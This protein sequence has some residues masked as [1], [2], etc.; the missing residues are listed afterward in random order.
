M[1]L[2]KIRYTFSV[3]LC[4][5]AIAVSKAQVSFTAQVV[6]ATCSSNGSILVNATGGSS[7]NYELASTCLALPLFQQNSTFNNLAP[8]QYTITVTDG[9]TGASASQTVTVGGTYQS[10]N[11]NL[12]CGNCSIEATTMGGSAP[13]EYSISS[14][15][16]GGPFTPNTP[17]GNAI[18]DNIQSA[19]N[20]WVKVTDAC[21]NVSVET[22]QTG[23]GSVTNFTHE[24]GADGQIH[25][26]SVTG[27]TGVIIYELSS[28]AGTF[29]NTTGVFPQ[30]QWGC[31]MMLTVA[32]GCTSITKTI[33]LKPY[34]QS[35]CSNFAEGTA[36]LGNVFNGVPPY[37]FKYTSPTNI[38]TSTMTNELTGLPINTNYYLFQVVD[39]CGNVSDA[40]Y[41]QKKYPLFEQ[42][43]P[44]DCDGN[45]I[46]LYTPN[47]GCSG[48]FDA[49]SWPFDVTCLS[50]S[51]V[52]TKSVDTAGVSITFNGNTP[53]AW[54]LA[55]EDGC[56]DKMVCRDSVILLLKPYCDSIQ[57]SLVD[58][59]TCD[60]GAI[61][62]RPM[63][64]ENGVFVLLDA[65]DDVLGSNSTG[66]FHVPDSGSYK[67]TLSLPNCGVFEATAN[68][69]YWQAV[70]PVMQTLIYNTVIGGQC[71][72]V[73]QL[74]IDPLNGPFLLTGGPNNITMQLDAS[75]LTSSCQFY[76]VHGLLPGEYQLTETDHCGSKN[77]HLPAPVYNLQAVPF[78][79]CPG[80]GTITVFGAQKLPEWQ[81]WGTVNN[82]T[83]NWPSSIT[84]NYAL[85]TTS[86][87]TLTGQSGSPY[88]FVNVEAGEHKIY[89]YTLNSQCPVDTVTVIVPEADTLSFDVS[90]GILC[91]N[92]STT[93]LSFEVLSGKPPYTIERVNCNNPALVLAT[94]NV[95]GNTLSLPGFTTGDY[96]FRLVDSCITSLDHQFSVQYFQDDIGLT[97]NCDNSFT[98]SVDSL[99][100]TYTWLDA[101][102]NTVGNSQKLTLPNPNTAVE[103]TVNVDIGQCVIQRS[104][105]VPATEIIPSVQ[106]TGEPY[107]CIN[108]SMTLAAVTNA[109]E[110]LWNNGSTTSSIVTPDE[111]EYTV[112]VT[113]EFGCTSTTKFVLT[114]D[115]PE[116]DIQIMSGG[117]GFGLNCFQDS[118]GIL[119]V[120]PMVGI[121]P[122]TYQWSNQAT[123]QTITNLKTG[124]F[125]VTLTDAI[126]C[127]DSAKLLLTEPELFVPTL[128]YISPRCF[129]I[130][131]G[132]IEIP[133]WTGGAGGVKASLQGS[134]P[135]L[136]PIIFDQLPPGSYS[137]EISD[138]NGCTVDSIFFFDSPQQRYLELGEDL[139]LE[140]GDSTFLR[141]QVSFAPVDSFLWKSN[142]PRPL[143]ELELW[144]Q[145]IETSF[146]ALTVWDDKG[147]PVEDKMNILVNKEL[148]IFAPTAFSPNGDGFNDRFTI[149]AR[150]SAVRMIQRLQ[151]F[152]RFGEKVF[153]QTKFDPNDE[154]MGW[155]GT[156]DGQPLNPGVFTWK[157]E[158]EFIDG[159]VELLYGDVVLVR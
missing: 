88:T 109:N 80:S 9:G 6:D 104:I 62:D 92:A 1:I 93:S 45:T 55:V 98:I 17:V 20:Y 140:L 31:N 90:S 59:F 110:Y 94:Y 16:L 129:G 149:F 53:G 40:I 108:D 22:C 79:N 81:N 58:R 82:A 47:G 111:G 131:D 159:R 158:I 48:G 84:D 96:C 29:S 126:G 102:G 65:N 137:I 99:N 33:K 57:A 133:F 95:N 46:T 146:Y 152:D 35:I 101:N 11:V 49:D 76:S 150:K 5:A 117:S 107:F 138:A 12:F 75:D 103:Y 70:D 7:L 113:N 86:N 21:G 153:E 122:F 120:N 4:I 34:V 52:V 77:I 60:N 144:V 87:G 42:A 89:L 24:I 30:S 15:G 115:I 28:T 134:L 74:V 145:P 119:T 155:N 78:G 142:D 23:E 128:N 156:L 106:I 68:I 18:F 63:S 56:E 105:T 100:A 32:D 72:T 13:F 154:P 147:C 27:G 66:Q 139:A 136:A 141:P 112:T 121:A 64:I 38:V 91:D 73:Y 36:T 69:G 151:L 124:E 157:A 8:C 43:P 97:F 61:S 10:P 54:E 130:D 14:V 148:D 50:C 37:T 51:P 83:I 132:V 71:K 85:D 67:V 127:V 44:A 135:K 114:R 2:M 143:M 118:N 26:L 41:K 3:L 125:S 25:V 123:T 19:T 39:A 116:I